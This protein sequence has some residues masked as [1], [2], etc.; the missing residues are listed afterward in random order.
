MKFAKTIEEQ[1]IAEWRSK[2]IDYKYLKKLIK[3]IPEK[4]SVDDFAAVHAI[5]VECLDEE[6]QKET[7]P[8]RDLKEEELEFVTFLSKELRKTEDFYFTHINR[9][10]ERKSFI[11]LQLSHL[12]KSY[13]S[14]IKT[15]SPVNNASTDTSSTTGESDEGIK[16]GIESTPSEFPLFNKSSKTTYSIPTSRL[17]YSFTAKQFRSAKVQLKKAII[18]LY[19][20]LELLKSFRTLNVVA[21][22]KITKKFEK[23]TDIRYHKKLMADLFSSTFY[24]TTENDKLLKECQSIFQYYYTSGN[25]EKAVNKL[26]TNSFPASS[27]Y[28]S[29]HLFIF[30]LFNLKILSIGCFTAVNIILI[31]QILSYLTVAS[32]P[33]SSLDGIALIYF[34]LG[35]PIFIAN[36]IGINMIVW[37]SYKVNYRLICGVNPQ[38]SSIDYAYFVSFLGVLYLT[39][40]YFSLGGYFSPFLSYPLQIWLILV[41]LTLTVLN[42]FSV[43]YNFTSRF[44][45]ATVLFRIFSSPY[46]KCKFKDFFLADQLVS[47][48]PF[49][50]S[51]GLLLYLSLYGEQSLNAVYPFTW[52]IAYLPLVPFH[53]R[54]WQCIRRYADA[55]LVTTDKTQLYNCSRYCLGMTVY[56]VIGLQSYFKDIKSLVYLVLPLRMIYTLFS[57]YWDIVMDWGLGQGRMFYSNVRKDPYWSESHDTKGKMTIYP[58]W[59]YFFVMTTNILARFLW[60][61]FILFQI[62]DYHPYYPAY[63]AGIVETLRRFQWNFIRMEIEH[64]HNCEKYQVTTDIQLPFSSQDLFQPD[65]EEEEEE[66]EEQEVD[67]ELGNCGVAC[68]GENESDEENAIRRD[69]SEAN[70]LERQEEDDDDFREMDDFGMTL[71]SSREQK[72]ST[73][74]F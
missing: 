22:T 45:F 33:H 48:I 66:G 11:I 70:F 6:N 50:Q 64:V 5:L 9:A 62:Y 52:Y 35:F 20:S 73:V 68:R 44:W 27:S 43:L 34:G 46:H 69:S 24:Q 10:K 13:S 65:E 32:R 36:L 42:Y 57:C 58:Q 55:R 17:F 1:A 39:L 23:N 72:G 14:H 28:Y 71:S 38:T 18:E 8:Q 7:E 12:L 56:I 30:S 16:I 4:V 47:I 3:K 60:L 61:P 40:V 15:I 21:Y 74:L 25:R 31:I 51:F 26:R 19:R 53:F 54:I 29:K 59:V 63:I 2:Y 67:E 41:I 49:Y 37:D